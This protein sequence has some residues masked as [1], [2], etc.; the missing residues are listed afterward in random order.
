MPSPLA[1]LAVLAALIIAA[2]VVFV[3]SCLLEWRR[4]MRADANEEAQLVALLFQSRARDANV[5]GTD[6]EAA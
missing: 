4:V 5:G 3:V 6:R 1:V 2:F